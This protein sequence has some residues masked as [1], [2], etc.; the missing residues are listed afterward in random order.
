MTGPGT[1]EVRALEVDAIGNV[2]VTGQSYGNIYPNGP[3][4][5]ENSSS[6]VFLFV[7]RPSAPAVVRQDSVELPTNTRQRR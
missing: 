3:M 1:Q 6:N 2:Y 7:F 4:P 5:P